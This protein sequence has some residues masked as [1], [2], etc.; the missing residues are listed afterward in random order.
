MKMSC[1]SHWNRKEGRSGTLTVE[2]S[3]AQRY[4]MMA[5]GHEKASQGT[6]STEAIW[7]GLFSPFFSFFFFFFQGMFRALVTI[8][9][10]IFRWNFNL[11]LFKDEVPREQ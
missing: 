1:V 5:D 3:P 8:C 6:D 2:P 9:G 10:G 11:G 7:R 4:Q